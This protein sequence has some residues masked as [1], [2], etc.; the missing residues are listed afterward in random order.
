MSDLPSYAVVFEGKPACPCL[1]AWYP[2]FRSE[3]ARR[4]WTVGTFHIYQLIGGEP[5]SGGTHTSGGAGDDNQTS[6]NAIW[7]ARQMGADASWHRPVNWDGDNGIAHAHRV[8]R[9]CPHNG[10][11]RYQYDSTTQGVDHNRDGLSHGGRGAPDDGPRPLSQRT[12]RE[13][14]EWAKQQEDDMAN[15]DEVLA[16]VERIE[17]KFDTFRKASRER[18][19]AFRKTVL[20]RLDA[21]AA[22][23]T[24]DATKAQVRAL[25]ADVAALAEPD[26]DET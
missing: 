16:A 24:D 26:D 5:Q 25:R 21:L 6:D 18:D 23:V 22:E 15:A 20:G 11:A 13:G 9:G 14:I 4:G 19:Q 3:L 17:R 2:A 12:W 7:L 10:P 8:L 1:A